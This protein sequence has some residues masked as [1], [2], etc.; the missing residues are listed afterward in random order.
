LYISNRDIFI[1]RETKKVRRAILKSVLRLKIFL[2]K[3][4]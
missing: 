4:S 2:E 1:L 3:N